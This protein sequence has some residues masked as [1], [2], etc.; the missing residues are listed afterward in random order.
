MAYFMEQKREFHVKPYSLR[1]KTKM[2][3]GEIPIDKRAQD[4]VMHMLAVVWV[5]IQNTLTESVNMA[6][7]VEQKERIST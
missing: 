3:G 6:Y 4:Y 1:S 7:F 2:G 5:S